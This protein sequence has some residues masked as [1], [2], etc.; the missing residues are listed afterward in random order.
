M[1]TMPFNI[2]D[3]II[4]NNGDTVVQILQ[5]YG[6]P[7]AQS[8]E[9]LQYQVHEAVNTHGSAFMKEFLEAH[10]DKDMILEA[11]GM[12]GG[13]LLSNIGQKFGRLP[14]IVQYGVLG[15]MAY[16]SINFLLKR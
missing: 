15:F 4:I 13:G 9:E 7:P 11:Y 8:I 3:Y 2:E 16:A 6:Y 12:G 1:E 14:V 10:P 5:K